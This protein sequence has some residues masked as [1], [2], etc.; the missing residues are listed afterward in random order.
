MQEIAT[1]PATDSLRARSE[2]TKDALMRA[3][4]KLVAGGGMENL[5]IKLTRFV[6]SSLFLFVFAFSMP[7]EANPPKRDLNELSLNDKKH[8][9]ATNGEAWFSIWKGKVDKLDKT[10]RPTLQSLSSI[11]RSEAF[12]EDGL[13]AGKYSKEIAAGET[14]LLFAPYLINLPTKKPMFGFSYQQPDDTGAL[15][16]RVMSNS[17]ASDAG[18]VEGDLIKSVNGIALS[19]LS[20]QEVAITLK[21]DRDSPT[22]LIVV[23]KTHRTEKTVKIQRRLVQSHETFYR[24][25]MLAIHRSIDETFFARTHDSNKWIEF[26]GTG[27]RAWRYGGFNVGIRV[28]ADKRTQD[29]K[30][31]FQ[32][33]IAP[34]HIPEP[35]DMPAIKPRLAGDWQAVPLSERNDLLIRLHQ[36]LPTVGAPVE[37]NAP[38]RRLALPFYDNASLVEVEAN[39]SG[40]LIGTYS[41]IVSATHVVL[42]DG[43]SN[44]IYRANPVFGLKINSADIAIEY[45][46]FFT[47]SIEG[48]NG[49][50]IVSKMADELSF[51]RPVLNVLV[52]AIDSKL[53]P[54]Q[55][56]LSDQIFRASC[57][58]SYG[59]GLFEAHLSTTASGQV[60][61]E[62]D[63][64]LV[65]KL[66][67]R[68][69]Y[70]NLGMRAAS[71]YY[72]NEEFLQQYFIAAQLGNAKA[73]NQI[74]Y[75]YETGEGVEK[76][77]AKAA[78]WY[79]KSASQGYVYAQTNL[80]EPYHNGNGLPKDQKTAAKWYLRAANQGFA[81]AQYLLAKAHETGAGVTKDVKL[82]SDWYK[83][84]A[85]QGQVSAMTSLGRMYQSGLGVERNEH[86]AERWY[87]KAA[88]TGDKFANKLIKL[89]R[90]LSNLDWNLE[91]L[92]TKIHGA[93]P[94]IASMSNSN[95]ADYARRVWKIDCPQVFRRYGVI[96]APDPEDR[97]YRFTCATSSAHT[98]W[99]VGLRAKDDT[100]YY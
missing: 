56:K 70:S 19:N 72:D 8:Y 63:A 22:E 36:K 45:I 58:I 98:T 92:T 43:Q 44:T 76:N 82:A 53:A 14:M 99:T 12:K 80:G 26:T 49:P 52:E 75:R 73:Q 37:F 89:S 24:T 47:S 23:D 13:P 41:F 86:E 27:T 38:M 20:L 65:D 11:A 69:Q 79:Q 25:G 60:N 9:Q 90:E 59:N 97:K 2:A 57:H 77:F 3:A 67:T 34:A 21:T 54:C 39:L 88:A 5:S 30:V 48:D 78:S 74:G 71:G 83:K 7:V 4:E 94:R 66:P 61:M 87:A 10:G 1:K 95:L 40:K 91:R 42:L 85:A 6:F 35:P 81:R 62:S 51:S 32:F 46:K 29:E 15:V 50:F 17:P 93:T 64:V 33:A 100:D 28:A 96:P 16:E 31:H 18:I 55:P 84:A 68:T